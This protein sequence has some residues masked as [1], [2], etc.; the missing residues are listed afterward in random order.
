M[1]HGSICLAAILSAVQPVCGCV[2]EGVQQPGK[3]FFLGDA[4]GGAVDRQFVYFQHQSGGPVHKQPLDRGPR[5]RESSAN[6]WHGKM[7]LQ[8][9]RGKRCCGR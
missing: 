5:G 4:G 1:R 3:F 2:P 7:F 6:G 9:L 8:H